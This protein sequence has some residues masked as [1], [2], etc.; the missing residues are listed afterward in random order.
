[1]AQLSIRPRFGRSIS[2]L[3]GCNRPRPLR[4]VVDAAQRRFEIGNEGVIRPV[5]RARTRDKH[6]IGSRPSLTQQSRRHHAAQPPLRPVTGYRVTDLSARSK[7]DANQRGPPRSLRP[8]RRLQNQPGPN[9]PAASGS[10]TQ[11]IG[12]GL[13]R[14]KPTGCRIPGCVDWV[15]RD[16]RFKRID[17]YGPWPAAPPKLC[18]PPPSPCVPGIRGGACERGCWADKCASR[19]RF[20]IKASLSSGGRY[21]EEPVWQVNGAWEARCGHQRYRWVCSND[22]AGAHCR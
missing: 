7:P 4:A 15:G 6:I 2:I 18:G 5:D 9:R 1:M 16:Q 3:V 8:P 21:I 20:R 11:E 22:G 19:H 12:P 17:V 14:Y 13:E 10:D